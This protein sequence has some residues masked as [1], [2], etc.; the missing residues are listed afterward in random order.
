MPDSKDTLA[1]T[2]D[3]QWTEHLGQCGTLRSFPART[4]IINEGD[5]S[6]ALFLI[7]EG[8][9]RIYS[10]NEHGKTVIFAKFGPGDLLGEPTLDGGLRTASVMTLQKTICRVIPIDE[11][12]SMIAGHPAL[13]LRV[14]SKLIVL[15][16]TSNAHIKSLALDDVYARIVRLLMQK[17]ALVGKL[18]V[19]HE[20]LTQQDIAD[21]VGCSREMVNRIMSDLDRG[22][23]LS[24]EGHTLVIHKQFPS[25]W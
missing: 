17:S 10:T 14:I 7:K 22:G 5:S 12:I 18:R 11:Y 13:A 23:Y 19:V 25:R 16:R 9:G 2:M 15:I 8:A 20:K 21:H 4:I 1:A 24:L 6:D 3:S